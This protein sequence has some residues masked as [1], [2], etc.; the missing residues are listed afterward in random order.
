MSGKLNSGTQICKDTQRKASTHSK[1][2]RINDEMDPQ[3]EL[4]FAFYERLRRLGPAREAS[5]RRALTLV[6]DLP[7]FRMTESA[8]NA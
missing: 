7:W 4:M 5:T 1:S 8:A 6:S 2:L 3:L